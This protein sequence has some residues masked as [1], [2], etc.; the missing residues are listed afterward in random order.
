MTDFAILVG[1]FF[2][3]VAILVASEYRAFAK[4]TTTI[5]EYVHGALFRSPLATLWTGF[6]A[7]S[8]LLHFATPACRVCG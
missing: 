5:S 6:G 3:W 4:G 8:L 1:T 2:A 7:G